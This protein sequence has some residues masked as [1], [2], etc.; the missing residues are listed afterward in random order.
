MVSRSGHHRAS[1]RRGRT[2][3]RR[4]G[5][6]ST[7]AI[8]LAFLVGA[9]SALREDTRAQ[10]STSPG[11]PGELAAPTVAPPVPEGAVGFARAKGVTLY[12]PPRTSEGNARPHLIAYHEASLDDASSLTPTGRLARNANRTKFDPPDDEEGPRYIVMSSRGR[13]TSATSAADMVF[14]PGSRAVSPVAG[15]V[16]QVKPY[17]LYGRYQDERVEISVAGHPEVHVV[18]IHLAHVRVSRGDEVSAT[19]S[20]IGVPRVFPF[21]SQVDDYLTGGGPHV[22]VEIKRPASTAP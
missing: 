15:V 6:A 10:P 17:R 21:R 14:D 5:I 13:G 2:S 16:V 20:V 8:V 4:W 19:L 11:S 3:N 9:S 12:L 18:M 1:H 7:A 22:H